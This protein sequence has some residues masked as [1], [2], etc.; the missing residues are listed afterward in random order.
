[1]T[2][3][4]GELPQLAARE[5]KMS[6]RPPMTNAERL[7]ATLLFFFASG[8]DARKVMDDEGKSVGVRTPSENDLE[9]ML[10]TTPMSV[11][12][13]AMRVSEYLVQ[14]IVETE[15]RDTAAVFRDTMT[16]LKKGRDLIEKFVAPN[17]VRPLNET[18]GRK[19]GK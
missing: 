17:G 19:R 6:D 7:C 5:K 4:P 12:A 14:Q 10:D 3:S 16:T 9:N 18:L 15:P 2:L 1:M 13:G 8:M 11:W